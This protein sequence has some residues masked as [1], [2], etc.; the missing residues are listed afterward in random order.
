MSVATSKIVEIPQ[1]VVSIGECAFSGCGI[2]ESI[3]S[4]SKCD[5]NR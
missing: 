3:K 4:P 2:L 5:I 1:G